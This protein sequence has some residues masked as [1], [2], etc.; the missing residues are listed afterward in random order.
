MTS[1]PTAITNSAYADESPSP[2]S[3]TTPERGP[4]VARI[5]TRCLL[6]L[7]AL[8][9]TASAVVIAVEQR[10]QTAILRDQACYERAAAVA[11][12][13]LVEIGNKKAP[14]SDPALLILDC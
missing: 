9:V 2:T 14:S 8:A 13:V 1:D 10:Q 6:G 3:S 4:A 5:I 12:A 7:A 11:Q